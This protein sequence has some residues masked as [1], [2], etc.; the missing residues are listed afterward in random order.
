MLKATAT[1]PDGRSLLVIGLSFGNLGKFID[2]PGR[3]MIRVDGEEMG[4][5]VDVLLFSGETEAEMHK[6][7]AGAIG[8][9]TVVHDY[10]PGPTGDFPKGKLNE[11]DEGGLQI[12]VT[13]DEGVVKVAFG[14]PTAWLGLPPEEAVQLAGLI[15][16]HAMDLKGGR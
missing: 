12:V 11:D 16:K 4:L 5:P 2:E 7:M 8:P 6:T 3:T 14:K 10:R 15:V 13:H 9:E 1:G